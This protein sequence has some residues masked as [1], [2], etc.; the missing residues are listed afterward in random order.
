[1]MPWRPRFLLLKAIKLE[2]QHLDLPTKRH[3]GVNGY[4]RQSIMLMDLLND[5]KLV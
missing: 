5:I 4:T 3:L 2:R 1:M